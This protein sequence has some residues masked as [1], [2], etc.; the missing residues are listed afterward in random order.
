M[1]SK[2]QTVV[3]ECAQQLRVMGDLIHWKRISVDSSHA[4]SSASEEPLLWNQACFWRDDGP[5]ILQISHIQT[6]TQGSLGQ[7]VL[8]NAKCTSFAL[9]LFCWVHQRNLTLP[10]K[11][12]AQRHPSPSPGHI[13]L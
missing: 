12:Q 8:V 2:E 9:S 1:A 5:F 13:Q 11:Q 3:A 6:K 10:H 4:V 7:I